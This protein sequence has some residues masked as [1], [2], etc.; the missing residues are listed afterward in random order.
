MED[1]GGTNYGSQFKNLGKLVANVK[2]ELLDKLD[3]SL[4]T[5][6]SSQ[7]SRYFISVRV[8]ITLHLSLPD[9][10]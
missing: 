3:G 7:P 10:A 8:R 6:S 2:K 1:N 9:L 4:A 5:T